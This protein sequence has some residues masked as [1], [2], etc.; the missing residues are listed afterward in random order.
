MFQRGHQTARKRISAPAFTPPGSRLSAPGQTQSDRLAP[1]W[2]T[3]SNLAVFKF[4]W[5][6]YVKMEACSGFAKAF[7]IGL[8]G[9]ATCDGTL[10]PGF[11]DQE[12]E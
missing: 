10:R 8:A 7:V 12:R 11:N 5:A 4:G 2:A 6:A 3:R 1:M 9:R